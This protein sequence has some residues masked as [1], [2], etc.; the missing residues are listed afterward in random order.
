MPAGVAADPPLGEP[1][2]AQVDGMARYGH[3][4]GGDGGMAARRLAAAVREA[5]DLRRQAQEERTRADGLQDQLWELQGLLQQSQSNY[6][7][8]VRLPAWLCL[9]PDVALTASLPH[10]QLK[11]F[12]DGRGAPGAASGGLGG[13]ALYMTRGGGGDGGGQ[14][15]GLLAGAADLHSGRGGWRAGLD[16]AVLSGY[17]DGYGGGAAGRGRPGEGGLT[18]Q[19]F[20]GSTGYGG[21]PRDASQGGAH[22]GPGG[23]DEG[24]QGEGEPGAGGPPPP[25]E[26][27]F[28]SAAVKR[29]K[30]HL[31][32]GVQ[33]ATDPPGHLPVPPHKVNPDALTVARWEAFNARQ[34]LL[35]ALAEGRLQAQAQAEAQARAEAEEAERQRV[36]ALKAAAAAEQEKVAA[37]MGSW[38][39]LH[40]W[41]AGGNA[42][43][44]GTPPPLKRRSSSARP[45]RREAPP[46][47]RDGGGGQ[48]G[49][50]PGAEQQEQQQAAPDGEEETQPAEEV[51]ADAQ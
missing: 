7:A 35:A 18:G 47:Q 19:T 30:E 38:C 39:G 1:L 9:R 43:G 26:G 33:D 15:A 20:V 40:A 34:G 14:F 11:A 42:P 51:D 21:H 49:E 8:L 41:G 28:Q 48:G 29:A 2:H 10:L 5:E 25:V 13:S 50:A 3:R 36:E 37:E 4:E 45:S 32:A 44:S 27:P 24:E 17:G 46:A 12:S 16:E 31:K 6:D 22:G 23:G